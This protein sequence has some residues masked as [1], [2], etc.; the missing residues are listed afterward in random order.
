MALKVG[1]KPTPGNWALPR[2]DAY[3]PDLFYLREKTMTK[4]ELTDLQLLL[5]RQVIKQ[6]VK[7]F[8]YDHALTGLPEEVRRAE[9]LEN[10]DRMFESEHESQYIDPHP[11]EEEDT[12]KI[13]LF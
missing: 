12:Q 1:T 13:K 9:I 6:A 7:D 3:R 10:I 8:R 4:V 2:T 5:L 11:L